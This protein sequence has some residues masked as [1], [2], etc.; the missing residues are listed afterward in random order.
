MH[1]FISLQ[2][3][4]RTIGRETQGFNIPNVALQ[5]IVEESYDEIGAQ[6]SSQG[7]TRIQNETKGRS[8]RLG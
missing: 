1:A 2:L 3:P 6:Y 5:L 7:I 4:P 8:Y